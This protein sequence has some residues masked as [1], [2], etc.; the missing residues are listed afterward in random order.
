VPST[1]HWASAGPATRRWDQPERGAR[2]R[3]AQH[4]HPNAHNRAEADWAPLRHITLVSSAF[5][6][7]RPGGSRSAGRAD[8]GTVNVHVRRDR[9]A[10]AEQ[11]QAAGASLSDVP[12]VAGQIDVAGIRR[13]TRACEEVARSTFLRRIGTAKQTESPA[14]S[15]NI[16]SRSSTTVASRRS[17]GHEASRSQG[18]SFDRRARR[19]RRRRTPGHRT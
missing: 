9:T 6:R 18:N 13:G 12:I 10:K 5:H 11:C 16:D 17:G 1:V 14:T 3:P 8:H 19:G 7:S 15:S 2:P 4:D